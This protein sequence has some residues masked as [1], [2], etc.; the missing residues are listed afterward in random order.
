MECTRSS[1]ST[2][3][4][5]VRKSVARSSFEEVAHNVEEAT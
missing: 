5:A 2:Y 1:G 4:N 3:L